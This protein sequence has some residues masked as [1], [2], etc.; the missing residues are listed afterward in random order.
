MPARWASKAMVRHVDFLPGALG[1]HGRFQAGEGQ[2]FMLWKGL[3]GCLV[4]ETGGARG[5]WT[6]AGTTERVGGRP[7]RGEGEEAAGARH[8]LPLSRGSHRPRAAPGFWRALRPL[9]RRS[10]P[11]CS[12]R[13]RS[14][15]AAPLPGSSSPRDLSLAHPPACPGGPGMRNLVQEIP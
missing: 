1:S 8:P 7:R 2:V 4:W 9:R 10:L 6:R 14:G 12:R 5:I 15:S 11:P 13:S 3:S